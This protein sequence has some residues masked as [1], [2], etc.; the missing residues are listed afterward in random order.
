MPVAVDIVRIAELARLGLSAQEREKLV[1]EFASIVEYVEQLKEVDVEGIEPTAHAAPL[2][3]VLR[4][5]V[6][7]EGLPRQTMLSNAPDTVQGELVKVKQVL[8]GEG[9]A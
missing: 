2:L 5:D 3:N 6:A 8:P 1:R 4:D 7:V 9:M